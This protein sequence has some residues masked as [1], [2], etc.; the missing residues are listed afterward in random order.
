MLV[1][2]YHSILNYMLMTETKLCVYFLKLVC[3]HFVLH[4]NFYLQRV[5]L[6]LNGVYFWSC[7]HPNEVP[8]HMFL[9]LAHF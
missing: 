8:K 1:S 6:K 2:K 9:A 3:F 4:K 5:I 7:A